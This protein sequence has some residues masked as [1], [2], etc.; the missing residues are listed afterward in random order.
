MKK[1]VMLVAVVM[2]GLWTITGCGPS[3][4]SVLEKSAVSVL[5]ELYADG[6]LKSAKPKCLKVTITSKT[7]ENK[8]RATAY[9][10]DGSEPKVDIEDRGDMI[11]VSL[12][13]DFI[14]V[15]HGNRVPTEKLGRII[16]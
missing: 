11:Y 1:L 6:A 3:R 7:G 16:K 9:F 10:D 13:T 4:E 8:Y 12:V 5:T 14:F 15:R 2:L